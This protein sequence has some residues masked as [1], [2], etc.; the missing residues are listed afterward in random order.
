MAPIARSKWPL[1]VSSNH[2]EFDDRAQVALDIERFLQHR[3]DRLRPELEAGDVADQEVQPLMPFGVAG[4]RHQRA[5]A[6]LIAA[7]GSVW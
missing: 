2:T 4:R 7:V 3:L 5:C 6:S 1:A